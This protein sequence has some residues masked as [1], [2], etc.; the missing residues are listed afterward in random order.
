[1]PFTTYTT[2]ELRAY[3]SPQILGVVGPTKW[4]LLAK[5]RGL[6]V[7]SALILAGEVLSE[8]NE[9][10]GRCRGKKIMRSDFSFCFRPLAL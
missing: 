2:W 8:M 10:A 3:N 1:L 9:T 6:G 7:P 5:T 4:P